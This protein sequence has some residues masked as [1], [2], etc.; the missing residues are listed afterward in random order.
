MRLLWGYHW[1]RAK[2]PES[3]C[4]PKIRERNGRTDLTERCSVLRCKARRVA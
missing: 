3:A 1:C 4:L 2:W